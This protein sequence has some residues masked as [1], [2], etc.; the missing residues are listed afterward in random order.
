[1]SFVGG[2]IGASVAIVVL[3]LFCFF[4]IWAGFAIVVVVATVDVYDFFV[5]VGFWCF[6]TVDCLV[7]ISLEKSIPLMVWGLC[8][9]LIRRRSI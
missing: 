3:L 2:G 5:D 7:G 9:R 8:L 1:L 4:D 6:S